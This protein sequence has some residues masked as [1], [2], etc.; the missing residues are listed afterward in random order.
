MISDIQRFRIKRDE[1]FLKHLNGSYIKLVSNRILPDIPIKPDISRTTKWYVGN[2]F[3]RHIVAVSVVLLFMLSFFAL[4]PSS[5]EPSTLRAYS[6]ITYNYKWS[7]FLFRIS[8]ITAVFWLVHFIS[9]M[10]MMT[11]SVPFISQN[12][13]QTVFRVL[14]RQNDR[15]VL[16][17]WEWLVFLFKNGRP[18]FYS[19]RTYSKINKI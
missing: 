8:C 2:G 12:A 1:E 19:F 18:K 3:E 4:K 15:W 14:Q 5:R 17:L 13:K 11:T 16:V 10:I 9:C 6:K 7:A